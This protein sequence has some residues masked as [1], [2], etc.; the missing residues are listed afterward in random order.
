MK[1]RGFFQTAFVALAGLFVPWRAK[2]NPFEGATKAAFHG[3]WV[4]AQAATEIDEYVVY[5]K[6]GEYKVNAPLD[7]GKVWT[8]F[9]RENTVYVSQER[10]DDLMGGP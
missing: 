8:E 1:R 6:P 10:W 7:F 5:F 9:K 4:N 2:V 3:K